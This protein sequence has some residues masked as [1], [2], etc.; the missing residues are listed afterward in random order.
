LG[1]R[2]GSVVELLPSMH[3]THCK[4]KK[5]MNINLNL[6]IISDLSYFLEINY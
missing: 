6:K 4:K 5:K 3:D 1:L 2:V